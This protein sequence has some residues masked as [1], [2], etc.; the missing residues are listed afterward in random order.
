MLRKI[1]LTLV[2]LVIAL[3]VALS[4]TG[5]MAWDKRELNRANSALNEQLM[6]ANLEVGPA[7]TQ[8]GNA[9]AYAKD[10]EKGLQAEID[11]R[12]AEITR[13]GEL[14][15]KY[16]ISKKFK[17]KGEIIYVQGPKTKRDKFTTGQLYTAIDERTLKAVGRIEAQYQDIRIDALCRFTPDP[18]I[19]PRI[20]FEFDYNLH[21][22]L[23]GELVETLTSSGAVNHYF[24]LWELDENGKRLERLEISKF[25]TIVNDQRTTQFYWWTPKL[26]VGVLLGFRGNGQF[27]PGGSLGV[28]AMG[29]GLTKND[30]SWRFLH[31]SMDLSGQAGVGFDP[32][33]Y[34]LGQ[35]LPLIS[36]LWI[37]PHFTYFLSKDREWMLAIMFGAVL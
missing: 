28:S 4:L 1:N 31:L 19:A 20:P 24:N 12:N 26:D 2:S 6:Q 21:L 14:L 10:L 27:S 13:Y 16:N 18:D 5:K 15:A 22:L 7:H 32:F 17:G 37:S 3:A 29:F 8:F 34:N 11:A 9:E 25:N 23:A 33:Q 35:N 30:L 36:N